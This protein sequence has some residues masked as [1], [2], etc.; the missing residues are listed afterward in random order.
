[1]LNNKKELQSATFKVCWKRRTYGI[2][3]VVKCLCD[4]LLCTESFWV[5]FPCNC[6][7]FFSFSGLSQSAGNRGLLLSLPDVKTHPG[8]IDS[9]TLF[10]FSFSVL[11]CL[12]SHWEDSKI[13][14]SPHS[15]TQWGR[16]QPAAFQHFQAATSASFHYLWFLLITNVTLTLVKV[17]EFSEACWIIH[18]LN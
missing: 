4:P 8:R 14:A 18:I 2:L 15:S 17:A 11:C 10:H 13:L 6:S 16:G 9:S 1:M 5:T 7:C 12:D 3:K